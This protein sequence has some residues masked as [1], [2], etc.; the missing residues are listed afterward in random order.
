[1]TDAPAIW[2]RRNLLG[3]SMKVFVSPVVRNFEQYRAAARKKAPTGKRFTKRVQE[4]QPSV[5][6]L[7]V[8]FL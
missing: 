2:T 3:I 4:S 8:V 7:L 6:G 5:R 1:M